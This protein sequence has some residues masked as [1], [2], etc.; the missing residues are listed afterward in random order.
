[1]MADDPRNARGNACSNASFMR[2][3]CPKK[4]PR[5]LE[6]PD[7]GSPARARNSRTQRWF[8]TSRD[9]LPGPPDVSR[10]AWRLGRSAPPG[11]PVVVDRV[12]DEP[13]RAGVGVR[14]PAGLFVDR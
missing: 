13:R 4:S 9:L 7:R 14:K 1:M 6:Q 12:E 11:V 3:E 8:C 5:L 10:A 2:W